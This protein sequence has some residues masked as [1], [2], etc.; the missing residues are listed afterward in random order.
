MPRCSRRSAEA[1][2]WTIDAAVEGVHFRRD[3]MSLEDIGYRSLM[4]AASD[5]ACAWAR[6]RGVLS[7]L[8]LPR[9]FSDEEL[10]RLARGQAGAAESLGTAVIGGNL[11]RGGELS[12]TT[13]VLGSAEGRS[14]ARGPR[15]GDVVAIAGALGLAGAGV[16]RART[17]LRLLAAEGRGPPIER[18]IASIGDL[19]PCI[20]AGLAGSV[21]RAA[22]IDVSTGSPW[23]SARLAAE[24][25]VGIVLDA[26]KVLAREGQSSRR[27]WPPLVRSTRSISP[28]HGGDDYARMVAVFRPV[29]S[30]AISGRSARARPVA[31][32]VLSR[33]GWRVSAA[34][35]TR[36]RPFRAT[37]R[38]GGLE[39]GEEL[40][41]A[42]VDLDEHAFGVFA[43]EAR[44]EVE[45]R[46]LPASRIS[47]RSASYTRPMSALSS[48]MRAFVSPPFAEDV[49]A[50]IAGATRAR[51]ELRSRLSLPPLASLKQ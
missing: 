29:R 30:F 50:D 14:Y 41:A 18:A 27:R 24:S 13:T 47:C 46:D 39:R 8:V 7:A 35:A 31:G 11:A 51:G 6:A 28:L 1:L 48:T 3:W 19:G 23:T 26:D 43:D 10:D 2:V 22:A 38:A 17:Q 9:D 20:E 45:K 4:A 21:P 33:G 36:L 40:T 15:R 49:A 16:A 37:E 5:L 42:E 12:I 32:Y 34:R 44:A 25:G